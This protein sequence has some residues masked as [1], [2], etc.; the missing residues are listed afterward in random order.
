LIDTP[1]TEHTELSEADE[2]A[3]FEA[4]LSDDGNMLPEAEQNST[5]DDSAPVDAAPPEGEPSEDEQDES[6]PR[7]ESD[8]PIAPPRSWS[9]EQ[10]EVFRQLPREVQDII[11]EREN[12]RD[13]SLR[14]H[15]NQVAEQEK[16]A[17]A[18]LERMQTV[19]MQYAQNLK[20]LYALMLPER[21]QLSKI[22]WDHLAAYDRD[23][24]TRLKQLQETS[25]RRV[26][27]LG[28]EFQR[29]QQSI[30][31]EQTQRRD[32]HIAGEL[33][34][35]YE[36]IPEFNVVDDGT[37]KFQFKDEAKAQQV[38]NG[39]VDVLKM[40]D[41][42]ENDIAAIWQ[43]HRI[44]KLLTRYSKLEAAEQA[45]TRAQGKRQV[46][47][48]PRIMSPTPVPPQSERSKQA[49]RT[50]VNRLR[51]TGSVDDEVRLFEMM[52]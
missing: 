9:A 30:Q 28:Q 23:E 21:E 7:S 48:N 25:D 43:D 10:Q 35:A 36:V 18:N 31:A 2:V 6:D 24:W 19:E 20:Q 16:A 15:L 8:S 50:Q 38:V 39:I 47:Q 11:T 3:R 12:D 27:I 40:H 26:A 46:P 33:A 29:V 41:F 45:R 1:E 14:R 17:K 34:K 22:D 5:G 32:Q 52:L 44:M 51:Q 49:I 13:A 42:G 4:L 37:G